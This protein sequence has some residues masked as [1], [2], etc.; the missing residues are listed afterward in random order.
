M[1]LQIPPPQIRPGDY[2]TI[3]GQDTEAER[4]DAKRVLQLQGCK[5]FRFERLDNGQLLAHGYLTAGMEFV[6]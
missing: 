1:N 3:R 2:T 6:R 4:E 5:S